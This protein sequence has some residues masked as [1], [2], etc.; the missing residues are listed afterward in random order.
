MDIVLLGIQ[1]SGKGTL[2]KAVAKK[3]GFELFETGAELRKLSQ[4]KSPLGRK[5]KTIVETGQL[6]PNEVVMDIISSFMD[7]LSKGKDVLFDGIP[8]K[9]EQADSFNALMQKLGRNFMGILIDVSEDVAI[10]RLTLRRLCQNCKTVY[11]AD[12]SKAVCQKCA[13][14]LITRNDDNPQSIKTR[15][16]AFYQETTPVINRYKE[17]EKIIVMNGDRDI[18]SCQE[19]IFT[20]IAKLKQ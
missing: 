10:K 6:V 5:V 4:K 2:G 3:Y 19:E 8:R 7:Q 9:I 11:P 15:F 20:I 17:Q 18:K 1:G 12:Y 14:A 16:K 13:G